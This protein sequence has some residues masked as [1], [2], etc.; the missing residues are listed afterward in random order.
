MKQCKRKRYVI[1][2][3]VVPL[4]LTLS[5]V[6]AQ[7]LPS[8]TVLAVAWSPDGS[9]LAVAGT[10]GV[11]VIDAASNQELPGFEDAAPPVYAIA[12]SPDGNKLA[13]S[14]A[15]KLINIWDVYN[16]TLITSLAGHDFSRLADMEWSPDGT[17]LASA[18]ATIDDFTLR[19]WDVVN[20]L[21]LAQFDASSL[22]EVVWSSD[23]S[24]LIVANTIIGVYIFDSSLAIPNAEGIQE[25]RI[26]PIEPIGSIALHPDGT[27]LAIGSFH[28]PVIYLW[29]IAANQQI[30]I[31]Q[32]HTDFVLALD[33]RPGTDILASVSLDGTLRTWDAA[34]GQQQ[35]IDVIDVGAKLYTVDWSPDGS[36]LVYGGETP[37]G[38]TTILKTIQFP[39]ANAGPDQTVPAGTGATAWVTLDGSGSSDND[40]TIVAYRWYENDTLIA[41][42]VTP[43]VELG[44]GVHT[45]TLVVENN[46]SATA[47]DEVVIT[48]VAASGCVPVAPADPPTTTVAAGDTAALIAAISAANANADPDIIALEAGTYT[49]TAPNNTLYGKNGLPVINTPITIYGNC[50]TIERDPAAEAFRLFYVTSAGNLTLYDL[51]LA[52][53]DG[54]TSNGGAIYSQGTVTATNT[55]IG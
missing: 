5:G 40:G 8:P 39:V 55:I 35:Q 47:S 50:A 12:W 4:L 54:G 3:V 24:Q 42:G 49:L 36:R 29:D 28:Q 7:S 13:S 17:K 20:A 38:Q 2:A 34:S 25:Y 45:I 18:A 32:G 51:T 52:G 11:R 6:A 48:V 10:E 9:K 33:W 30:G 27:T 43:Q 19:I 1:A 23:S 41:E 22:A 14:G 46:D 16:G 15:D 26:G 53:G 37:D 31:L 44:V 21:P